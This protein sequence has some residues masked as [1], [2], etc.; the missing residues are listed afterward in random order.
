MRA[1][2]S[3]P[4]LANVPSTEG[5]GDLDGTFETTVMGRLGG[6]QP[7]PAMTPRLLQVI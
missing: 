2:Q 5:K 3:I 4:G 1:E 7:A 6:Q